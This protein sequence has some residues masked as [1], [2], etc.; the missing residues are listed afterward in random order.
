MTGQSN[1]HTHTTYCDGMNTPREM[2]DAAIMKGFR[3]LGF[4]G[5]VPA[6][7]DPS[8]CMT[9]LGALAYK[10]EVRRLGEEYAGRIKIYLGVED[11]ACVSYHPTGWIM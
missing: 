10:E 7:F 5:H 6:P 9:P 3:T 11:D 8:Y 2:A 4:S 1:L